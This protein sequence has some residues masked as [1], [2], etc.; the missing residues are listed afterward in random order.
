M[1]DDNSDIRTAY[2]GS[3]TGIFGPPPID[4]TLICNDGSV[5]EIFGSVTDR[6]GIG[7]PAIVGSFAE[8]DGNAGIE[9]RLMG[10][11]T[12]S[13]GSTK[14]AAMLTDRLGDGMATDK[15]GNPTDKEGRDGMAGSVTDKLGTGTITGID[16]KR[17]MKAAIIACADKIGIATGF[18][19]APPA[20][21]NAT[22]GATS[23]GDGV[24]NNGN[25]AGIIF[26]I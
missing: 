25:G 23:N 22:D 12:D 11:V 26:Y 24:C 20:E 1:S 16:S 4:G 14:S 2:S 9:G 8:T 6:F 13:L 7:R 15:E 3:G 18:M 5:T 10:T 19:N 21:I 17:A